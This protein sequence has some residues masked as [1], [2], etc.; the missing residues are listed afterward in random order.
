M[1]KDKLIKST[2]SKNGKKG[3]STK[4]KS[5]TGGTLSNKAVAIAG[6]AA[7]AGGY[8]SGTQGGQETMRKLPRPFGLPPLLT[9][10]VLGIAVGAKGNLRLLAA[11]SGIIGAFQLGIKQ[12]ASEALAPPPDAAAQAAAAAA[13][14]AMSAVMDL[15]VESHHDVSDYHE[16]AAVAEVDC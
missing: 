9:L 2:G 10:G 16:Q 1:A 13:T 8:Y 7:A 3:S 6:I 14:N 11:A 5:P 15:P 4:K 12:S